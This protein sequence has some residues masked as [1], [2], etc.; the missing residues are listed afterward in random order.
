MRSAYNRSLQ[1]FIISEVEFLRMRKCFQKSHSFD[2]FYILPDTLNVSSRVL[3]P[4]R[5]IAVVMVLNNFNY[6]SFHEYEENE[7]TKL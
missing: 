6:G 3:K 4:F 5:Y 2:G 1:G 7:I